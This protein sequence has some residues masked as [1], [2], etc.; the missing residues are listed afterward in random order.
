MWTIGV[1][2]KMSLVVSKDDRGLDRSCA[3]SH[4][5]TKLASIQGALKILPFYRE[6]APGIILSSTIW[7]VALRG[8]GYSANAEVPDQA[9]ILLQEHVNTIIKHH[10]STKPSMIPA[11]IEIAWLVAGR[12]GDVAQLA[13]EDVTVDTNGVLMVRF[14]RGKTAR[15]GQYSIATTLPSPYSQPYRQE[16]SRTTSGH[17]SRCTG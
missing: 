11:L 7:K 15:R 6:N 5:L 13:P 14:R 1:H 12:V 4:L 10:N 16:K 17:T 2:E 8:A 9:P 3:I